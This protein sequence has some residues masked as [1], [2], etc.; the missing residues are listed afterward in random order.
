MIHI[1]PNQVHHRRDKTGYSKY[2]QI[3]IPLSNAL[4]TGKSEI[5]FYLQ[6]HIPKLLDFCNKAELFYYS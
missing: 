4:A 5:L 1:P 6:I 2:A 3:E